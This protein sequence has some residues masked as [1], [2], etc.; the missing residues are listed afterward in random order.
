MTCNSN[1]VTFWG[2]NSYGAVNP[3]DTSNWQ[4]S[5]SYYCQDDSINAFPI[6]FVDE[7]FSTG[8]L[9]HIDLSSTCSVSSNGAF[10]GT[11]LANCSFLQK[12]IQFCQSKGK[13]VT[14]SLGGQ[15]GAS[16]F[17]SDAQAQQFADTIWN[18][19]LGGTSTTRPFGDVWLDGVDLDIEN[20]STSYTAFV[21][22]LQTHFVGAPKK[23]YMTASPQCPYPDA[24]LSTTLNTSY[25]GDNWNYAIWD[26][27]ARYVS[28]NKNVKLYIG[29]PAAAG[30]AGSGYVSTASLQ[31]IVQDTR[32]NFPG[33][34][35]GVMFWDASQAYANGRYDKSTKTMLKSGKVCTSTGQAITYQPCTAAA[36][37]STTAYGGG[38]QVKYQG[39]QWQAKWWTS[40]NP[41][42]GTDS[43]NTKGPGLT[44]GDVTP[45]MFQK[46]RPTTQQPEY[47]FSIDQLP[48]ELFHSIILLA[49]A[50]G[51]PSNDFFGYYRQLFAIQNVSSGWSKVAVSNAPAWTNLSSS[52]P[53]EAVEMILSRSGNQPLAIIC[54]TVGEAECWGDK[55]HW[56]IDRLK[57]LSLRWKVLD[58]DSRTDE[59]FITCLH[60]LALPNLAEL[61]IYAGPSEAPRT[62]RIENNLPQISVLEVTGVCPQFSEPIPVHS[63]AVIGI[64]GR[65]V[66][67]A[68]PLEHLFQAISSIQYLH[69]EYITAEFAF[70]ELSRISLPN[71]LHSL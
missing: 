44:F 71:L 28:P 66:D 10:P 14:I 16:S 1:L 49:L 69:L 58:M 31:T 70:K 40:G 68:P 15:H 27:W 19:F 48:I 61:R 62:I 29:G 60:D 33:F 6:A 34:F 26:Y 24:A 21:K 7:Y 25:P 9:P 38:S 30:A 22:R 54:Q 47:S 56:F 39:Y 50:D 37:S 11:N 17:S 43:T 59:D 2:Q 63:V 5:L 3:S 41:P 45:T 35:G 20:G 4:K 57:P 42:V 12:D 55:E 23:Y 53:P 8:G 51:R 65:D 67:V 46:T 64:I 13:L 52:M 18:L 32:K 36:W